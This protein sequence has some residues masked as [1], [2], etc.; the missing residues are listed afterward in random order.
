MTDR[1][2]GAS[3]YREEVTQRYGLAAPGWWNF[4]GSSSYKKRIKQNNEDTDIVVRVNRTDPNHNKSIER[5]Q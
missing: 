5:G 3:L 1:E 4:R 2:A